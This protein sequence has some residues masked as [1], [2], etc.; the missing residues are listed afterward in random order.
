M[1]ALRTLPRIILD[2]VHA[3]GIGLIKRKTSTKQNKKAFRI[4]M[5]R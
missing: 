3:G 5:V 4:G 2:K 1:F